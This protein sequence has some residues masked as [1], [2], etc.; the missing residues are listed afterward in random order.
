[1]PTSENL[2]LPGFEPMASTE[3]TPSAAA[4]PVRTSVS[5]ARVPAWAVSDPACGESFAV[6]LASF[7]PV[8]CTWKTSGLYEAEDSCEFS[9]TL[10]RSGMT[11][12]GT[13]YLLPPLVRLTSVIVS[14]SSQSLA[15]TPTARLGDQRGMPSERLAA[16]RWKT[17]SN[18]DD[19]AVLNPGGLL[20][21]PQAYGSGKSNAPGLTPLDIALRPE[22]AQHAERA[23]DRRKGI[24]LEQTKA[25]LML[26]TSLASDS[27]QAGGLSAYERGTRGLSLTTWARIDSSA[28][29]PTPQAQ[30]F[31]NCADYSDGSRGKSPQLRHLGS[32]RLNPRFVEWMMG[33]PPGWTDLDELDMPS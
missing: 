25:R 15:P 13:L 1:M 33:Y 28:L 27:E 19:W 16:E 23:K 12:S 29:L 31:R 2:T 3:S 30:D 22:M 18:L 14:G 9:Q 26:P 4:S 7:D 21:T 6:S 8:L 32:G 24:P 10:P 17:R 20:P 5:R 11:R